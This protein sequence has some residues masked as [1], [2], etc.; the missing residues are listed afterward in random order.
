LVLGVG[1]LR[2]RERGVRVG[3]EKRERGGPYGDVTCLT[4]GVATAGCSA[5]AQSWAVGLDVA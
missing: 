1:Q 3:G 4:A 2:W 5:Y